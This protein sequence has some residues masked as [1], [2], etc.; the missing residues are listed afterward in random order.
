MVRVE[1]AGT[2][3]ETGELVDSFNRMASDIEAYEKAR[4]VLTA[5]IAHELRTP[6][7]ILKGRLHGLEDGVIDPVTGEATRLLRQV[8][9]ILHIVEDL[10][11]LAHA[12]VGELTLDLRVVDLADVLRAL[13]ADVRGVVDVRGVSFAENYV[14]AKVLGDPARLTQI[15]TNIVANAIKHA[16]NDRQVQV[17][18]EVTN[19]AVVTSIIDEGPGFAPGD[20]QRLFTPFWRAGANKHAGRPGIG[21]GL[22]LAAKLTEAHGGRITAKNRDDRSGACF[23]VWLPLAPPRA[24]AGAV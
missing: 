2:T 24:G 10:G 18:M 8:E 4:T 6:L 22:A 19:G 1:K 20:E 3:G 21:M 13:V 7:T 11:T 9:H 12:D 17:T 23:S 14:P 5:G 15:F 16:P